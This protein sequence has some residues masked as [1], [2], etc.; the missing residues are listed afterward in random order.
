MK[1]YTDVG[2]SNPSG[3]CYAVAMTDRDA[4][5]NLKEMAPYVLP[6]VWDYKKLDK[7]RRPL[8]PFPTR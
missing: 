5:T 1:C 8:T 7:T 2:S 3:L 4:G 6:S